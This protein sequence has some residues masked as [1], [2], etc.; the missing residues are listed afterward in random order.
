MRAVNLPTA[1][2][3]AG[4]NPPGSGGLAPGGLG[5]ALLGLPGLGRRPA[6]EFA[7]RLLIGAELAAGPGPP[8][9]PGAGLLPGLAGQLP[10]EPDTLAPSP[11]ALG[12]A[13]PGTPAGTR[14]PGTRRHRG[15]L[16]SR[17]ADTTGLADV[18]DGLGLQ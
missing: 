3:R 4:R 16:G 8:A 9:S 14:R 15:A 7:R 12:T 18:L 2:R 5:S 1:L 17:R 13:A 6:A 11:V 10:V